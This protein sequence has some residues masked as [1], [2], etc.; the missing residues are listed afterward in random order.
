MLAIS[1]NTKDKEDGKKEENEKK[2]I[3]KNRDTKD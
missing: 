3:V 1:R 2:Q